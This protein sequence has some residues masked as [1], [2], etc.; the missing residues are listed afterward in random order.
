MAAPRVL[1]LHNRYRIEG[2]EE[3]SVALQIDALRAAGIE[4]HALER[5]SGDASRTRAASALLRGGEKAGEI[6]AAVDR[7]GANVVHA[8]NMLPLIGPRGLVAARD[9]GAAVVLHLH[10]VR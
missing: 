3:R 1:V 2:G 4:H 9:R 8:H 5:S 6:A 7:L 10:N